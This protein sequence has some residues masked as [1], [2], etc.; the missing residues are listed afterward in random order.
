MRNNKGI[1]LVALVVTVIIALI[2]LGISITSSTDVFQKSK[3]A[4]YITYMNLVKARAEVVFEEEIFSVGNI[5][6]GESTNITDVKKI[7]GESEATDFDKKIN[8]YTNTPNSD[9]GF[10]KWNGEEL[11]SQGIDKSILNNNEYFVIIFDSEKM[12]TIDVIYSSG[13]R[14]DRTTYYTLTDMQ[15]VI[16]DVA[17]S[18]P[19]E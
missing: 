3:T 11:A 6:T 2:I 13:C 7:D 1:T 5:Q 19:E 10:I 17:N 15:K 12:E 9:I 8:N 18:S 14:I 16:N 4:D